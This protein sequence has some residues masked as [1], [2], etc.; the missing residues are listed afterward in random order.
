M[1]GRLLTAAGLTMALP[2]IVAIYYR[3]PPAAFAAFLVPMALMAAL[4][5]ALTKLPGEKTAYFARDGL[6]IVGLGWVLLTLFGALPYVILPTGI[7]FTDAFFESCSSLST[8]GATV[9]SDLSVFPRS[10]LFWRSYSLFLGG[11]G[12]LVVVITALPTAGSTGVYIMRAEYPGKKISGRART[13]VFIYYLIY[14]LITLSCV[15]ALI[16]TGMPAFD[17]LLISFS[18]SGTGGFFTSNR[19]AAVY[20]EPSA[21]VVMTV[22]M[23]LFAM[24]YG[25]FFLLFTGKFKKLFR[26]EEFRWYLGIVLISGILI[27]LNLRPL[28]RDPFKMIREAFFTVT[29]ILSTTSFSIA[30]ATKWPTFSQII[31]LLLAFSGGMSGSTTGAMKI[32]RII[33]YLKSAVRELRLAV[34]PNR[35]IP[36]RLDG[37]II[38]DKKLSGIQRYLIVYLIVFFTMLLLTSFSAPNFSSAFSAVVATLNN[39]GHGL[40]LFGTAADYSVFSPFAKVVFSFG[41]LMGRLEIYPILILLSPSTYKKG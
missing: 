28:Y 13:S 20:S 32:Y 36:I 12:I 1:I 2:I 15:T 9:F 37:E 27:S 38:P 6:V 30:D 14:I 35:N 11:L 8:T 26:D 7:S 10:L 33:V 23:F 25:L 3:E 39:T 18:L 24:N 21:V 41:M 4:G 29:S 31:L 16:L 19:G 40:D 22:F 17:A 5:N 34:Y